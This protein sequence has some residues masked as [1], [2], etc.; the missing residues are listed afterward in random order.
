MSRIRPPEKRK[1]FLKPIKYVNRGILVQAL[2][3]SR[4]D[5]QV[6][7]NKSN[8][9]PPWL[10]NSLIEWPPG[11]DEIEGRWCI[12]SCEDF[13][14][15]GGYP[16][17]HY[18]LGGEGQILNPHNCFAPVQKN[19]HVWYIFANFCLPFPQSSPSFQ[20]FLLFFPRVELTRIRPSGKYSDLYP[21]VKL[22]NRILI[23]TSKYMDPDP[24]F[25]KIPG[26]W[27]RPSRNKP[28]HDATLLKV[29]SGSG[30]N[31]WEKKRIQIWPAK[32]GLRTQPLK[33]LNPD[34]YQDLT[35]RASVFSSENKS[36]PNFEGWIRTRHSRKNPGPILLWK[37]DPDP[38]IAPESGSTTIL[39]IEQIVKF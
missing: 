24:A 34:Q 37:P 31:R 1:W 7:L 2:T 29:G 6:P 33:N 9:P 23:Q 15:V 18:F 17:F 28:D 19:L 27:F 38:T 12:I 39:L 21:T 25:K 8:L 35:E 32:N 4:S 22:K 36:R 13:Y 14:S 16:G 20:A 30:T 5:L 26:S 11:S 3:K 10:P